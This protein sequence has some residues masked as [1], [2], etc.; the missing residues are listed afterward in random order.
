MDEI[1][2]I[3]DAIK[4]MKEQ[5]ENYKEEVE[6]MRRLCDAHVIL[7]EKHSLRNSRF[8][9]FI[10]RVQFNFENNDYKQIYSDIINFRSQENF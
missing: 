8:E 7:I 1:T 6:R 9:D 3:E 10:K 5:F 4:Y 2:E